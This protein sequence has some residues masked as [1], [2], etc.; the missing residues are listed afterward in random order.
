MKVLIKGL[1][2]KKWTKKTLLKNKTLM[3][4]IKKPLW[5]KIGPQIPLKDLIR[6]NRKKYFF[7]IVITNSQYWMTMNS[8]SKKFNT[9]IFLSWKIPKLFTKKISR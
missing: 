1:K 2:L 4:R 3:K 6:K 9:K 8:M 5:W 7:K